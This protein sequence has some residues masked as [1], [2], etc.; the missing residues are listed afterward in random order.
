MK[1]IG[2]GYPLANPQPVLSSLQGFQGDGRHR[3]RIIVRQLDSQAAG[4]ANST[5]LVFAF[6][7]R[8]KLIPEPHLEVPSA[9]RSPLSG[10]HCSRHQLWPKPHRMAGLELYRGCCIVKIL[11]HQLQ[12]L[13]AKRDPYHHTYTIK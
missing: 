9:I 2:L 7:C 3:E 12:Y 8:T 4:S 5:P 13:C 6:W 11:E 1:E 10:L